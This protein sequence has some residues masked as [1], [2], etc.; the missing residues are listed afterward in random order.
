[1]GSNSFHKTYK[2]LINV[3]TYRRSLLLEDAI[4]LIKKYKGE[5]KIKD[6]FETLGVSKSL[7]E[8]RFSLAIGLTAKEFAKI[9]KLN[10]F[11]SNYYKYKDSLNLTQ[12]TFK[13]GY[14]DQ[15]HLIKDF[16]YY[17]DQ[18]PG[19]FLRSY[20]QWNADLDFFT[21][22]CHMIN[23]DFKAGFVTIMGKPNVGK[24]TLMNQLTGERISIVTNRAQ[25]TR[26][27][28]F[29]IITN[30]EHQIVYSDTPGTLDPSYK[31]QE[32]MMGF[33]KKSLEDA[34]IILFMVE[35]GEKNDH[36]TWL[37]MARQ[38]G[39]PII[40]AINKADLAKGSQVIDKINYW[41]E[42]YDWLDP[43]AFSAVTGDGIDE[44]EKRIIDL[45]PNHPPY[46]PEDE[47]TDKSER[48][49]ASE[50]IREKIFLNYKQEIPYSSEV[51]VTSFKEEENIIRVAAEIYVER[52][53]QKG[54]IIGKKGEGI[55][56]LGIESRQEMEEFFGK[57]IHLETFVKV[58]KDW[59]KDDQKLK[60]FGY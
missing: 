28:I 45:L 3:A 31:L 19:E 42:L 34:D 51:V 40:F 58:D 29:G 27:R 33:V 30:E 12:L 23:P 32:R 24:S 43:I 37:E 53:T 48:F 5:I 36:E 54:I 50:I 1:M 35:L 55:K 16:R 8:Q 10:H 59:R 15:S 20:T 14:Y 21:E 47:L 41:K 26:H 60:K 49:I 4:D 22:I 18:S 46:F 13:S 39:I 2:F 25:T 17:T 44:L 52:N 7:L 56:K 9:E 6:V 38:T 57:Q 11:I